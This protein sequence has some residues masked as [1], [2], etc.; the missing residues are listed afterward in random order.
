[1]RHVFDCLYGK[2]FSTLGYKAAPINIAKK[3][4]KNMIWQVLFGTVG[5]TIGRKAKYVTFIGIK[6]YQ[7]K[8]L[9]YCLQEHVFKCPQAESFSLHRENHPGPQQPISLKHCYLGSLEMCLLAFKTH[10]STKQH[11]LPP[12]DGNQCLWVYRL[13]RLYISKRSSSL[14]KQR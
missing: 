6:K 9:Q 12:F 4:K 11:I 3:A 8:T 7:A 14:L 13:T 5:E 10:T 2:T 1:M